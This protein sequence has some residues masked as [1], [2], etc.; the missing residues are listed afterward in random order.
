MF[1]KLLPRT[2]RTQRQ[3]RTLV[4]HFM[5]MF[6]FSLHVCRSAY[7]ICYF[8]ANKYYYTQV[9]SSIIDSSFNDAI[10][11][12]RSPVRPWRSSEH[13]FNLVLMKLVPRRV[14]ITHCCC[15]P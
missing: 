14:V 7:R 2:I 13:L 3:L 1:K 6:C 15:A 12:T 4:M 11:F 10:T 5:F 8:V 9:S